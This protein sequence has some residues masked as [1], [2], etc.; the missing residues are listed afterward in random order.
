MV[1]LELFGVTGSFPLTLG[2]RGVICL[3]ETAR[4]RMAL[5]TGDCPLFLTL[6]SGVLGTAGLR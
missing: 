4:S 3:V 6:D 2:A 1:F 5:E